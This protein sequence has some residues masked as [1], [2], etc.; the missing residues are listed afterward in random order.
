MLPSVAKLLFPPGIDLHQTGI[1]TVVW[2]VVDGRWIEIRLHLSNGPDQR[3]ID[4]IHLS[5]LIETK[6]KDR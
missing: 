1:V 3:R 5:G 6:S 4:L 2:V